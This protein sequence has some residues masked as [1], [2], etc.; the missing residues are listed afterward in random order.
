MKKKHCRKLTIPI[1]I[2]VII[3]IIAAVLFAPCL[4]RLCI[5]ESV[6]VNVASGVLAS[7]IVSIL[8]DYGSTQRRCEREEIVFR[9]TLEPLK[10]ACWDFP[11][12]VYYSLVDCGY[13][14][15]EQKTFDVW[16][17]KL[18]NLEIGLANQKDEIQSLIA[19]VSDIKAKAMAAKDLLTA[20]DN[21][22]V[23]ENMLKHLDELIS[24]CT[25]IKIA[26]GNAKYPDCE[27][28]IRNALKKNILALFPEL[29]DVYQSPYNEETLM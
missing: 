28:Q 23:T 17:G 10:T 26:G 11:Y 14:D 15:S 21:E 13:R 12:E 25:L 9:R 27:R 20:I 5:E 4:Q 1:F 2:Y 16:V 24:T 29:V 18:F 8:T 7:L 22:W 19:L 3:V 6:R